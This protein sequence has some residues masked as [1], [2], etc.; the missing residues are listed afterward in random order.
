MTSVLNAPVRFPPG[1][2]GDFI[3]GS[4]SGYSSDPLGFLSNCAHQYGD[5]IRFRFGSLV[6]YML[7]HPDYIE[8]VLVTK[9]SLFPRYLNEDGGNRVFGNG[10]V[11]S[12]WDFWRNQRRMIQPAFHRERIAAY[13]EVMVAHTNRMLATWE[14]GEIRDIHQDMMYLT[15]LIVAKTLFDAD[16]TPDVEDIGKAVKVVVQHLDEN[17]GSNALLVLLGSVLFRWLPTPRQLRF[18]KAIQRLDDIVYCTIREHRATGKDTGDLLS[19]LLEVQD[20]GESQMT[21]KQ[22]RDEVMNLVLAGY[23][24]TASALSWTWMLLSQNPEVEAKLLEELQAVLGGRTPTV[25]DLPQLRYTESVVLESMRLYPPIWMISLQAKQDCEI[26]GYPVPAGTLVI[27]NQWV[28]HRDP[29]YFDNPEEFEPD[30]WADDLAKRLPTYAY[31][32][33]GGGPRVCIGKS[34]AMMEAVLVVATIAQKFKLTL[35]PEHPIVPRP[36]I[37]LCPKHGMKMLLTKR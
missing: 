22:L 37:S 13:G 19:M 29:R 4:L 6:C 3:T 31:F 10:L 12:D 36:S 24:T 34:F 17:R 21:D 27:M 23:D 20:S 32:P 26:G 16:L 15:L 8:E 11:T 9:R 33:F 30:R 1:P 28:M 2:N 7:N 14:P 5:I 18:Q 35:V 25:A